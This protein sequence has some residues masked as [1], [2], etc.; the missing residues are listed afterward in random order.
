VENN[1]MN[2]RIG[3]GENV[4]S[5]PYAYD[6]SLSCQEAANWGHITSMIAPPSSVDVELSTDKPWTALNKTVATEEGSEQASKAG[7]L[8]PNAWSSWGGANVASYD[9]WPAMMTVMVNRI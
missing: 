3:Y 9:V 2:K 6:G 7:Q 5:Q 8:H 1:F 4:N